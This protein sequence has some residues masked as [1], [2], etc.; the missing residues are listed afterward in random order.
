MRVVDRFSG[1]SAPVRRGLFAIAV[2][3][4]NPTLGGDVHLVALAGDG[5]VVADDCPSCNP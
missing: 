4:P 5:K 1:A 2:A 3:D